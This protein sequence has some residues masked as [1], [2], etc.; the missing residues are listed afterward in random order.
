MIEN[1]EM[2]NNSEEKQTPK[3]TKEKTQ[4]QRKILINTFTDNNFEQTEQFCNNKIRTSKY[5]LLTF[6][7][8][9][10]FYQFN[11][12][13][14][15]FFLV[16][17]IIT[18]IPSISTITPISA[19]APFIVV[20]IIS[21]IKEGIEDYRKYKNDKIANNSISIIYK[22]P[23]FNEIKWYEMEVGNIIKI[24]KD[25][26]I[27][28]DILIIKTSHENG[29]C[30]LQTS[31]LDGETTL[32]PR[33]SINYSQ[34]NISL[35]DFSNDINN[36]FNY[37]NNNCFIEIDQPTRNIYEVEGTIFFKGNKFYFDIKNILLRGGRL[38]NTDFVYGIIVY[39][40][41]ETK[42]M[43]NINRS[44]LKISKKVFLFLP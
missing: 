10:L 2:E 24:S 33:E 23:S 19:V 4:K 5:T 8:L 25:E 27:P 9:A 43:K 16:T 11:S 28:A 29:F 12:A 42:L 21:L 36:I 34:K 20:L 30:Y 40:G 18:V 3:P 14:N 22:S 38:K 41:Q 37:H 17:A 31:N 39:S 1:E 32:K 15:L 26:I 6:L 35:I 13:F 7:P 44:S